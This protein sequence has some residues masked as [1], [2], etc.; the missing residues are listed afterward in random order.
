MQ[1]FCGS[2]ARS[3][4]ERRVTAIAGG[5]SYARAQAVNMLQICPMYLGVRLVVAQSFR[6]NSFGESDQ[7]R[8]CAADF[9]IRMDYNRID[10]GAGF[11]MTGGLLL[12]VKN[13]AEHVENNN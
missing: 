5:Q 6:K 9:V 7:F 13:G 8:Y 12:A 4:K 1:R 10:K 3:E 11:T 2:H